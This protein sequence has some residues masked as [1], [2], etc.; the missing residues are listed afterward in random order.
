M[1]WKRLLNIWTWLSNIGVTDTL[2]SGDAKRI[3]LTNRIA[4]IVGLFLSPFIFIYQDLGLLSGVIIQCI[5]V[6]IFFSVLLINRLHY[7]RASKHLLFIASN[8]N[9]FYTSAVFGFENGDHLA[10]LLIV[11]LAFST[12]DV[13]S[14]AYHLGFVLLCSFAVFILILTI[15]PGVFTDIVIDFET[16]RNNYIG[17]FILNLITTALIAYYFQTLS[18]QQTD[19]IIVR[20]RRQLQAVFDHSYDAM[21]LIHV[22]SC[23]IHE[24]N[25]RS[26]ELF[27]VEKEELVGLHCNT[28][29]Q[30]LFSEER[31]IERYKRLKKEGNVQ[32]EAVFSSQN[33]SFF[34]GNVAFTVL[35]S[36]EGELILVRIT[37]ISDQKWAE[38][39]MIKAKE[40]AEAAN[41]AKAYFLANMS[42]EL[43]TPINGII[44]LSEIIEAEYQDETLQMYA[45]LLLESGNRLLR[46]V[47]S[48]LDLSKLESG[49]TEL[50]LSKISLYDL[51]RERGLKFESQA[52]TK[53]LELYIPQPEANYIIETDVEFLQKILDHLIGN[54]IKFTEQGRVILEVDKRIRGGISWAEIRITDTGIGMS[55]DFV[56]NKIFMKFEQESEGLDRNYEGAGLG[57]SI[58]KRVVE[59]LSGTISVESERG[60]G[61]TFTI[62]FLLD[63]EEIPSLSSPLSE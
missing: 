59:L 56:M 57:L 19:D 51:V 35:G 13:R 55:E 48:V 38:A 33:G 25:L 11:L 21:I 3:R 6:S 52:K 17:S 8:F 47:S 31:R 26:L 29:H 58:T 34:W 30:H 36:E 42:H 24:C 7:Y 46:T 22:K 60:K 43:R 54:A 23:N 14:E 10:L 62:R 45:G 32:E 44:G 37:D 49:H 2:N 27:E 20:G 1:R 18:N 15:K 5:T 61:T 12:F 28:L 39:E 53:S 40:K 16:Q 4:F 9:V 50:S 63:K 41:I